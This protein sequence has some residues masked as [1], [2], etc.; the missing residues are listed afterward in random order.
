[1]QQPETTS[2]W[3]TLLPCQYGTHPR[4]TLAIRDANQQGDD[5]RKN[6]RGG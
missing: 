6:E 1:M 3:I 2:T 4:Q 5:E